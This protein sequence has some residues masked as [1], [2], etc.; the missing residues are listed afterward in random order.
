MT[1]PDAPTRVCFTL[2]VR[3]DRLAEYRARHTPV[4]AEM[5]AEIAG[6]AIAAPTESDPA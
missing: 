6:A 1:S 4:R 2:R 5:L 3:P